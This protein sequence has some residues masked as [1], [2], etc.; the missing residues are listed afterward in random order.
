M[1]KKQHQKVKLKETTDLFK[2]AGET[3]SLYAGAKRYG[4]VWYP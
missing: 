1:A 4:S 3:V 2:V